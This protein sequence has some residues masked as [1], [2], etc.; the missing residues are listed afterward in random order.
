MGLNLC[1]LFQWQIM[2]FV[3]SFAY[4]DLCNTGTTYVIDSV[5]ECRLGNFQACKNTKNL[6]N[7]K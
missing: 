2:I 6:L 4:R 1:I 5:L 3:F 7:V